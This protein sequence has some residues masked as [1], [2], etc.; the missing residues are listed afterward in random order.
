MKSIFILI[1]F[2]LAGYAVV[3]AMLYVFQEKF[4]FFP[5]TAPFGECPEMETR[6]ARAE[7]IENIRYYVK[8][9]QTPGA[10]IIL[11]HG[12]AGNAC[13]RTY[14]LDLLKEVNANVVVVEYPGFGRDSNRPGQSI[15]LNQ[16]HDLVRHIKEKNHEDLPVFLMGES[17]GTGVATWVATR[18]KISGLILIS[19]YT[20]ILEVARHHYPWAPVKY[21]IRHKFQADLWAGQ[22]RTPAILFHGVNDDIIPIQFARQQSLNFMG[23]SRLEELPDCGHND[24]ID[25]HGKRIQEEIC[26]FISAQP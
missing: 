12:N 15:I 10:W 19:A 22:T 5:G 14:Y 20:S 25:L 2:C 7:K 9:K 17:L 3:L 11:F 21:L 1:I 26:A 18:T 23:N 8:E 24:I 13:D 6:N 16:A 4:L